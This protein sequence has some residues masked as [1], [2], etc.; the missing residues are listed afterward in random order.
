MNKIAPLLITTILASSFNNQILN[1]K[2]DHETNII[3]SFSIV[4]PIDDASSSIINT[5]SPSSSSLN[6]SDV[7]ICDQYG[8]FY[9]PCQNFDATFKYALNSISSSEII[10]RIRLLDANNNVV[11]SSSKGAKN[12]T[13]GEMFSVTFTIPVRNYLTENGLTLKFEIID[14]YTYEIIKDFSSRFYPVTGVTVPYNTLKNSCY[15]SKSFGFYGDG[16]VMKNLTEAFDFRYLGD[17][18]N[19]NYY[20]DLDISKNYFYYQ[21]SHTISY[22]S[23]T[24]R[25]NDREN[26]FPYLTHQSNG[27]ILIPLSLK[28]DGYQISFMFKN[29]F[30]V[31]VKTLKISDT[32]RQDFALTKRFYL[33]VN[34]RDKMNG[35]TFYIDIDGLGTSE[36]STTIDLKY[37]ANKSLVG[38]STDGEN[39]VVG[40]N[41]Q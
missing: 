38:I 41:T 9:L 20:Y 31:D 11:A 27:D 26:Q 33:P 29:K 7:F 3:P 30:Y 24:L 32:Y 18:L 25:F 14:R 5:S 2:E 13:K 39:Y 23:I 37:Y 36:L 6:E 10:E 40:G 1:N 15:I 17:Y 19:V 34:G 8:P 16:T 21:Y 12:I 35:K 4:N 28:Q 22:K